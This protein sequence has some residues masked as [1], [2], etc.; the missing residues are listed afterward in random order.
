MQPICL[1]YT[2]D[3]A[4][5]YLDEGIRTEVAGWGATEERGTNPADVLQFLNVSTFDGNKC[6]QASATKILPLSDRDSGQGFF[7]CTF[8]GG[9]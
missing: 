8:R 5:S 6:E 3:K 9:F 4:E 1:P 2:D 7:V